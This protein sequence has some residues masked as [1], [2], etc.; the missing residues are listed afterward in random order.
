M[1]LCLIYPMI[2]S[3]FIV[4]GGGWEGPIAVTRGT[5]EIAVPFQTFGTKI[6][7]DD[8]IL[9]NQNDKLTPRSVYI[10]PMYHEH[11]EY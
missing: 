3:L 8:L 11:P 10:V 7:L 5:G 1:L 2:L 9:Y 4:F 6:V